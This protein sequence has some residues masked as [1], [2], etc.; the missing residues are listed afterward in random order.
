M[1]KPK[2]ELTA[3]LVRVEPEPNLEAQ[4]PQLQPQLQPQIQPVMSVAQRE[5][6]SPIFNVTAPIN[7]Q[8]LYFSQTSERTSQVAVNQ[9][10]EIA[11]EAIS[12]KISKDLK[13]SFHLWCVQR[14]VTMTDAIEAAIKKYL[15]E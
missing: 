2:F 12:M 11:R 9:Q 13:K 3:D 14:G 5:A 4:Q 1:A 8:E 10:P 6:Y 7:K 15:Q